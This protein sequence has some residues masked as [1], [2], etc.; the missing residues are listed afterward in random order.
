[1]KQFKKLTHL[2]L[3]AVIFPVLAAVSVS[4]QDNDEPP[5]RSI[6][7][8]DFQTKRPA[9]VSGNRKKSSRKKVISPVTNQK[10]RKSIAAVTNAGRRYKLV[11]RVAAPKTGV[12]AAVEPATNIKKPKPPKPQIA[13][14]VNE[15]ELGITFWRLRPLKKSEEEDAPT[16][17]VNTGDGKE[18]WTAERVRSTTKFK[19]GDRVRF[20]VESLRSG[21]LYIIN[22]EVFID[23]ST[24]EADLIYPEMSGRVR[25]DNR[26]SA[27][28]LVEIPST[29][30]EMPYFRIAPS[31]NDYAGEEVIV[32]ISPT[33]I[34][35]FNVGGEKQSVSRDT[36]QKWFNDWASVT[37]VYDASDGEGVAY[38]RT[39]AEAVNTRSL[40]QEEP[41]PQTIYRFKSVA[42]KPLM[43]SFQIQV[44]QE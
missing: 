36:L 21:F 14:P 38:T 18:D 43:I 37:D 7:S 32:I 13:A 28:R 17:E 42:G 23:G 33:K 26:V 30:E 20:T 10:R 25:R 19:P 34:T 12:L 2:L 29:S 8:Q 35:G 41:L 40:T 3:G 16:F 4:A 39:E 11:R 6:T 15:E 31:R 22:R 5:S 9:T 44:K 27:G 24:G 1:M